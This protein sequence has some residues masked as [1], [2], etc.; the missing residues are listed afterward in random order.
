MEEKEL[1]FSVGDCKVEQSR[2]VISVSFTD[3][4]GMVWTVLNPTVS[5]LPPEV[6]HAFETLR[7][8]SVLKVEDANGEG[9]AARRTHPSD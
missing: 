7:A 2:G 8:E 3:P 1:L 5:W 9:D 4:S 6:K